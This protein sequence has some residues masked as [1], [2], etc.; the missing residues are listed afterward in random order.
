M[1]R[2]LTLAPAPR[3]VSTALRL[4]LMFGGVL[5]VIGWALTC[6]GMIFVW[7]FVGNSE[8]N[9][10]G[11]FGADAGVVSGFVT[12]VE[13]TSMS[14]N[15]SRVQAVHYD[16]ELGGQKLSGTSYTT[17]STPP[18]GAEVDVEFVLGDPAMSRVLGMRT[19]PF[20]AVVAFVWIFPLIGV[21]FVAFGLRSGRNAVRLLE[22]GE[23]ARG[24][25]VAK[26]ATNTRINNQRVFRLTFEFE[27]ARGATQKAVV[28]S[29]LLAALEDEETEPLMY[30]PH[31]D[32]AVLLDALPGRPQVDADGGFETV[33]PGV[34]IAVLI[35]PALA[36]VG[37]GIVY[38]L[39]QAR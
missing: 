15:D 18:V 10:L 39:T 36:V 9:A 28:R 16:Y 13:A 2:P 38:A 31:R 7:V 3:R 1:A 12:G 29:H 23:F 6:F 37:N 4:R 20:S 8:L 21:A 19:A 24:R 33:R 27:D 5:N 14:E 34:A 11:K 32:A 22:H 35:L 25:L 26:E 30:D 17:R